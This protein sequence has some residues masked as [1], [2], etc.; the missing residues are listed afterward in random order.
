[1]NL[2]NHT[3]DHDEAVIF[4]H[5]NQTSQPIPSDQRQFRSSKECSLGD[6]NNLIEKEESRPLPTNKLESFKTSV[7]L[8]PV[9]PCHLL[10]TVCVL[11]SPLKNAIPNT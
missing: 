1:M 4:H 11:A 8:S 3:I 9:T 10:P 6:I 2:K 5:I 7:K